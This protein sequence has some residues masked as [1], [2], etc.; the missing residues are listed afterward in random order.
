MGNHTI[1]TFP[2]EP[3]PVYLQSNETH[4]NTLTVSGALLTVF[5]FSLKFM[6]NIV[7]AV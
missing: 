6:F 3:L 2:Q 5:M 4:L 7:L 1:K